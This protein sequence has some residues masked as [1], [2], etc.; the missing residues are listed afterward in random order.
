MNHRFYFLL[1]SCFFLSSAMAN[2]PM[3]KNDPN[4]QVREISDDLGITSEQFVVCFNNVRPS[5]AGAR[6]ES[7]KRV[8]ANK[9]VLLSCLQNANPTI[10][11]DSLDTVMDRYRPGGKAAQ[12]PLS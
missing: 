7:S 5:P 1:S 6:P 12:E 8:H 9:R 2:P 10:T 4:R 11:N 3:I